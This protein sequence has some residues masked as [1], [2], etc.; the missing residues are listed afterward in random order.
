MKR[1]DLPLLVISPRSAAEIA[2][3]EEMEARLA[4]KFKVTVARVNFLHSVE[5]HVLERRSNTMTFQSDIRGP[6]TDAT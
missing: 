6:S 1:S 3:R 5:A 2:I 4:Y